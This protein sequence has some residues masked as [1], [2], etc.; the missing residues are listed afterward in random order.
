MVVVVAPVEGGALAEEGP[1]SDGVSSAE[2]VSPSVGGAIDPAAISVVVALVT[3]VEREAGVS[4]CD[5]TSALVHAC[6]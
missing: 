1:A 5:C 2:A 6:C 4:G 3:G